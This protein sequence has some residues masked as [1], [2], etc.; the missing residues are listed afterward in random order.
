MCSTPPSSSSAA[1]LHLPIWIGYLE[2]MTL[3]DWGDRVGRHKQ[4]ITLA[5]AI[6]LSALCMSSLV[7]LV[8]FHRPVDAALAIVFGMVA[9]IRAV[10]WADARRN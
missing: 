4:G 7:A 1:W 2:D 3:K 8:R 6:F 9:I 10:Q 5:M